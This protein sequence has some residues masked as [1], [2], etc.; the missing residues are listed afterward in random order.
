MLGGQSHEIHRATRSRTALVD[1]TALANA[2]PAAE[3]PPAKSAGRDEDAADDL[4]K[5]SAVAKVVASAKLGK[6]NTK[7][8]VQIKSL[9]VAQKT[10]VAGR[11]GASIDIAVRDG[12]DATADALIKAKADLAA[13]GYEVDVQVSGERTVEERNAEGFANA[14]VIDD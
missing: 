1:K 7:E 8:E 5:N 6:A 11:I 9:F 10:L 13:Q 4:D 3:K 2:L 14:I 12:D